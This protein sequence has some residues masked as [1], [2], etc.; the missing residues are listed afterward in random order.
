MGYALMYDPRWLRSREKWL[1]NDLML[2]MSHETLCCTYLER[3]FV[4]N[5]RNKT[6]RR[7]VHTIIKDIT[8]RLIHCPCSTHQSRSYG[9]S[10]CSVT[11]IELIEVFKQIVHVDLWHSVA[12]LGIILFFFILLIHVHLMF[13]GSLLAHLV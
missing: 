3:T 8:W 11:H 12:A 2:D 6:K 10:L 13:L 7:P 4:F 9:D 5:P 1:E